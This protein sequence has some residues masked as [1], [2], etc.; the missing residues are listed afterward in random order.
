MVADFL[1]DAFRWPHTILCMSLAMVTDLVPIGPRLFSLFQCSVPVSNPKKT[2]TYLLLFV[3][4]R[5]QKFLWHHYRLLL[6]K[7]TRQIVIQCSERN[8]QSCNRITT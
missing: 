3:G 5:H 2:K 7:N 4:K 8:T 1:L 6:V